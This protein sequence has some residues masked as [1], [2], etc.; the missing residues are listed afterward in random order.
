MSHFLLS[1]HSSYT[2]FMYSDLV[3]T[4]SEVKAGSNV[5]VK[6]TVENVGQTDGHEVGLAIVIANYSLIHLCMQ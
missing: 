4:P 6:V 3:V 5:T 2:S 1:G